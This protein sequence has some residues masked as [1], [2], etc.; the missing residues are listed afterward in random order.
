MYMYNKMITIPSYIPIDPIKFKSFIIKMYK[1]DININGEFIDE[2]LHDDYKYHIYK[3]GKKKNTLKFY[4]NRKEVKKEN[5]TSLRTL[6]FNDNNK[7]K[8]LKL[9]TKV[10]SCID[11]EIENISH[12]IKNIDIIDK[13][14]DTY[15]NTTEYNYYNVKK[16]ILMDNKYRNIVDQLNYLNNNYEHLRNCYY[17][18]IEKHKNTYNFFVSLSMGLQKIHNEIKTF[19][20]DNNIIKIK[21]I[22]HKKILYYIEKLIP[23]KELILNLNF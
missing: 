8:D 10:E 19:K 3:K 12:K 16:E 13:N 22:E 11:D 18:L 14:L 23:R 21:E 1:I 20:I 4:K 9:E 7:K 2:I 15:N 17:Y 6:E 5:N